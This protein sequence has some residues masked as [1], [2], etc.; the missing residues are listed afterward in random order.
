MQVALAKPSLA[1]KISRINIKYYIQVKIVRRLHS[2][3]SR[4]LE[5]QKVFWATNKIQS[6]YMFL[7]RKTVQ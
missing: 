1:A 4:D 3:S 5:F 2:S 6:K 7:Q